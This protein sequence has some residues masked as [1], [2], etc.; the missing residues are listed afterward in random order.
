MKPFL[1]RIESSIVVGDGGTG[2]MIFQALP[3]SKCLELA[4]LE[5]SD[6]VLDT[7]LHFI[8][9]GAQLIQTNTFGAN[10]FK[11]KTVGFSDKTRAINSAAVKLARE[12]REISGK[13]VYIAGSMGPTGLRLD[14]QREIPRDR[15][16]ILDAFREQAAALDERGIDLFMV[17]TFASWEECLLAIEAVRDV[18]SLPIIGSLTFPDEWSPRPQTG[19]SARDAYAA[20][21]DA[22]AQVLGMNC[23]M[24]PSQ[25]LEALELLDFSS[26]I[27]MSV[28]PNVG[29]PEKRG[30]MFVYPLSSPEYFAYFAKEAVRL[31]A[32][33]V[34]GCCGSGPNHVEAIR[35]A[36]A[37]LK[38]AHRVGDQPRVTFTPPPV[39]MNERVLSPFAGKLEK[40]EFVN[41]VQ[42]DPPKGCN[43]EL[44]HTAVEAFL[45]SDKVDAVDV[46]SNPM[47]RLHMD[48]LWLSTE[49]QRRGME[50]IPHI[51]P[52]DA[53]LMGLE[54][55]L[56]GAWRTGIHNVLVVT[57]DP[58]QIGDYPG[59]HDVYQTDSVGLVQVLTEL[60]Q[61]RDWAGNS[62]GEPPSFT[63]GVA[64]N[65]NAE[66]LEKEVERFKQ[67][68]DHGA[69][70]AM[71]QVFF[72]WSC[73][74]RFLDLWGGALPIPV[75]IAV[76]PL[77]SYRLALRLHNEVPGIVVPAEVQ[78]RLEKAGN[79]ARA[80]GFDLAREIYAESRKRKEGGVY[81]IAPFKNPAAALEI[82]E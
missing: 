40:K 46:N 49:I 10:R 18:S 3:D 47:A 38:P 12:A 2:S 4:N 23:S 21:L 67:K 13:E 39:T 8:R 75:L 77:T 16:Q 60:N 37:D 28:H 17:E 73:W 26:D 57:G 56:L 62:I 6:A 11:L 54:A 45:S 76:W 52:R 1:E 25:I 43:T 79:G 41:V 24:G 36:V 15:P 20:V 44:V 66:D 74:E 72:E 50:T 34:G 55:S 81:I 53:S 14:P 7:H 71:T 69:H 82:L 30:G 51:T 58:S 42:L 35:D 70:F 68:V 78:S 27:M 5:N 31:G 32:R 65:P 19:Q 80:E 33:V 59:A 63:I 61:G 48:S 22:G 29:V 64:V 9:A